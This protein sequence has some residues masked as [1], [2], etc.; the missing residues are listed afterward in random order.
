MTAPTAPTAPATITRLT[1]ARFHD[2]ITGLAAL[3]TAAVADGA[4]L[5]FLAP[6]TQ[7][8]AAHW[9]HAQTPA[10]T[11]GTLTV[12]TAHHHG[13]LTGTIGL[14][15]APKAN[16]RHRA[17]IIKLMVH[18]RARRRGLARTLLTTAEHAA[19]QTGITLLLL[20]TETGSAAEHLYTTAGWTRYGTVPRYAADPAGSL[21]DCSFFYK[22]LHPDGPR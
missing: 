8:D 17:E 6:L 14:T 7:E 20:D 21:R 22:E 4:S 10:V 13:Q 1:P 11:D 9:W 18:P 15:T 16:G 5:G 3:L 2:S 12:W 19:A